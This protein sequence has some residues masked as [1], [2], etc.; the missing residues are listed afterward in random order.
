MINID[1]EYEVAIRKLIPTTIDRDFSDFK[2]RL[3][4]GGELPAVFPLSPYR[5]AWV[6]FQP[7]ADQRY[8]F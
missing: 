6:W 7:V 2:H 8:F 4:I 1:R 5:E 3:C